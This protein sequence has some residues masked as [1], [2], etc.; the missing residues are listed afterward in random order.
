MSLKTWALIALM[1]GS[2]RLFRGGLLSEHVI[3][4]LYT[5]IGAALLV[6]GRNFWQAWYQQRASG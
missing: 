2:G 3:G 1:V 5:A 4:L 6:G